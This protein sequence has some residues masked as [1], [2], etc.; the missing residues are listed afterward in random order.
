[1]FLR[2]P[3]AFFF[4]MVFPLLM[5]LL[6]SSMWGN[7]PFP[8]EAY[9]YVDFSVPAFMGMVMATSGIMSLTISIAAYREK[10]ILK[11]FRATPVSPSAI[12]LGQFASV[13]TVTVAGVILLLA[14]GF[15]FFSLQFLGNIFEFVFAFLL[16]ACSIA[17]MGFIPASLVSTARSGVVAANILYFPMLFLSGAALPWFMLPDFLKKVSLAFPLTH[18]IKLMQGVWLGGSLSDYPVQLAVLAGFVAAGLFVSVKY[19]RWE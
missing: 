13:F 15:V 5:M 12:L 11:R 8:G 4:T 18:A 3:S 17:A 7:E 6:F 14:A 1:M 19:F 2:E 9:G 10:G 16:S